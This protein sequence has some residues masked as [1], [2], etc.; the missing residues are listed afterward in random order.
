M[1]TIGNYEMKNNISEFTID[2]FS[3]I[4]NILNDNKLDYIDKYM[5]VFTTLGVSDEILDDLSTDDFIEYIK[6][7]NNDIKMENILLKEFELNGYTYVAYEDDEFKLKIKDM[8]LI[9]NAVKTNE[10]DYIS[11]IIAIIFKRSDLSKT[12]HYDKSHIEFKSKL[13]RELKLVDFYPYIVYI[14][15]KILNKMKIL[16]NE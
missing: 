4:T 16:I 6:G 1:I 11:K 3:K 8:A 2:E 5:N 9:E 7:F 14:Q 12:E 13:F 15:D 10:K